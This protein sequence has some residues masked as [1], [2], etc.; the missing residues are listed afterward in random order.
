MENFEKKLKKAF[1][2]EFQEIKEYYD[3]SNIDNFEDFLFFNIQ[4]YFLFRSI[5]RGLEKSKIE[6]IKSFLDKH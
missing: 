5:E 6:E 4:E 1:P 3:K 2:R